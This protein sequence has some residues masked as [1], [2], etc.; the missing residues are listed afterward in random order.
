[1]EL[2][3]IREKHL[4]KQ[5]GTNVEEQERKTVFSSRENYFNITIEDVKD[6]IRQMAKTLLEEY[7]MSI[8]KLGRLYDV[9]LDH[10]LN[11]F[12]EKKFLSLA[13]QWELNSIIGNL[14]EIRKSFTLGIVKGIFMEASQ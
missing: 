7:S 10:V 5:F 12:I 13:T 6:E 9:I 11:K 3:R 14:Q 8:V 1:M 4:G 2:T